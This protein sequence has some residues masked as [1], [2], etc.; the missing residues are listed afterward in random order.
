[1]K[2][3]YSLAKTCRIVIGK[4]HLE[5]TEGATYAAEH[6]GRSG[7]LIAF[8]AANVNILA[9]C[10]AVRVGIV[11]FAVGRAQE[12]KRTAVGIAALGDQLA[13]YVLGDADNIIHKTVRVLEYRCVY[14]LQN[15]SVAFFGSY[16]ICTVY[17]PFGAFME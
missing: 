12:A 11:A 1:M 5:M 14:L 2:I 6:L 9:P 3:R 13:S 10:A 7:R 8:N 4:L 16:E 17:M 15:I